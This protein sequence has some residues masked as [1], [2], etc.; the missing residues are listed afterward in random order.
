MPT[1]TLIL[2]R[3]DVA[4]LLDLKTC[5]AA[6]ERAFALH[7]AGQMPPPAIAAVHAER[8]GFHI[9]AASLV[10]GRA[11]VAVKVNGNFPGNAGRHGLPTIQGA[12]VLCDG[13]NGRVLAIMDSIAVTALRTAAASA[14]AARHLARPVDPVVA[15]CGC[16]VQGRVQLQALATLRPVRAVLAWDGDATR[17]AAF[18]R[19]VEASLGVPV[20]PAPTPR[21]A[22]GDCDIVVTCTSAQRWFLGRGDVRPGTFIAAVGADNEQK[23]EIEPELLAASTVVV[24]ILE[25]AA[26]IGD[27][28]H[29]IDAGVMT[30]EHVHAE[31]G[32]IV[33]GKASGR[34]S[35]EEIIVFDSTGTALQDVA[36]AAAVFERALAA[37]RGVT[38][39]LSE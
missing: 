18:A 23:Q 28:H 19:E 7:G 5:I 16:G 20:R 12:I 10:A 2:T 30:R 15:V 29:A 22:A 3:Q 24:D 34:R 35:E 13:T 6:V 17:A 14:V 1:G 27:L 26:T 37:G 8:G 33:A 36:S 25:Q 9:K 32:A 11:Y 38:V 31:L 4:A 39:P 21:A